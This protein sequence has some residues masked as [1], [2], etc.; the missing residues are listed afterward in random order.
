MRL[1]TT[2]AHCLSTLEVRGNQCGNRAMLSKGSREQFYLQ[3]CP[4]NPWRTFID[5]QLHNSNSALMVT[6]HS[7][8]MTVLPGHLHSV[9]SSSAL[10]MPSFY[11]A[12]N[13]FGLDAPLFQYKLILTNFICND[14]FPRSLACFLRSYSEVTVG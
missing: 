1:K 7:P 2:E 13:H 11:K 5:F 12:I 9:Y 4:S 6:R 3:V 14:L 8:S 10:H